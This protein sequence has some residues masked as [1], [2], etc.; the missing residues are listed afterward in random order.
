MSGDR[1]RSADRF[2]LFCC[3]RKHRPGGCDVCGEGAPS[4][5]VESGTLYLP[6]GTLLNGQYLVGRVLGTGGFGVT[7]LAVDVNLE[8]RFATKEYLPRELAGRASDGCTVLPHSGSEEADYKYGLDRF[9]QEGKHLVRFREHPN[10]ASVANFFMANGTCYL[11]M[12]YLEVDPLIL[13]PLS[14]WR[15]WEPQSN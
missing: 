2:C 14:P 1:N 6:P 3:K 15:D 7:Y 13:E 11:V 4:R 8:A 5:E 12:N 9:I 10:I